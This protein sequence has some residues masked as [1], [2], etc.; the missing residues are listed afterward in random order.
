MRL[1]FYFQTFLNSLL[2]DGRDNRIG[3]SDLYVN[4]KKIIFQSFDNIQN[5]S[6]KLL[7]IDRTKKKITQKAIIVN[8]IQED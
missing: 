3:L 1:F 8:S 5:I 6:L 4:K 2:T 7:R